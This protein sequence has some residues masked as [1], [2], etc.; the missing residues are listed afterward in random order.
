[1]IHGCLRRVTGARF[2]GRPL[3][4]SVPFSPLLT[5]FQQRLSGNL[6]LDDGRWVE[7]FA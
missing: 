6:D 4:V 3:M 5:T 1:M 7:V 2:A